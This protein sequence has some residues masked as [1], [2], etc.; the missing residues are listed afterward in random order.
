[1]NISVILAH[2]R[3]GSFNHAITDTAV[4]TLREAGHSVIVH[5]LYAEQFDSLLPA[6]EISRDAPLPPGIAAH[7]SEISSADGI[8]IVHPNWWGM[9][10]AILKGWI[11]RVLRPGVAYRFAETDSG[12]GIPIGLLKAKAV[13]VFNT[14]NTPAVREQE[15][16]GDPLE[17][18]WKDCIVSFCGVPV[19]HRRMFGVVVTSTAEQRKAWLEEA[20]QLM[21]GTFPRP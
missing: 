3:P 1:M 18:I 9:P 20:R 11:D 16:F 12:E 13:I 14:S 10:P 6:G 4:V 19:C 5:D 7:C 2:P 17:R 21:L 15:V 8:V